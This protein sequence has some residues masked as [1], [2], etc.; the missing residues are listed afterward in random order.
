MNQKPLTIN[1]FWKEQNS[2]KE[3]I[4]ETVKTV[5]LVENGEKIKLLEKA[6]NTYKELISEGSNK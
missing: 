5:W 1:D 2:K 4:T 6:T 3:R